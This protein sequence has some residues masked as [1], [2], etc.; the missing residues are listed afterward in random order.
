MTVMEEKD[1]EEKDKQQEEVEK[2]TPK[3]E[4]Q[5]RKNK[6]SKVEELQQQLGEAKDQYMRL[7]AEFD[8][9]RRRSAKERLELID[10]AGKDVLIGFLPVMDDCRMALQVLEKSDASDAA[11][12]GTQLI[13]NKLENYL[14][15]N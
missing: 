13:L 11:K 14:K 6:A 5:C 9:F 3:Q 15:Q 7:A 4:K 1:L 12:E 8:N 10:S 2:E